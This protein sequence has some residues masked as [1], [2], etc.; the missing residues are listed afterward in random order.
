MAKRTV[1]EFIAFRPIPGCRGAASCRPPGLGTWVCALGS[2]SRVALSSTRQVHRPTEG[3][4]PGRGST[5]VPNFGMPPSCR[6]RE[7]C[8]LR[9]AYMCYDHRHSEELPR[10][11][12]GYLRPPI[13]P[14]TFSDAPSRP[15]G[16]FG[17]VSRGMDRGAG[18]ISNAADSAMV[19]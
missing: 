3:Q 19:L 15:Y 12:R 5:T 11:G 18:K 6:A 7:R 17:V 13:C 4:K 2:R 10:R 9:Y 14:A 16:A 1:N 8:H